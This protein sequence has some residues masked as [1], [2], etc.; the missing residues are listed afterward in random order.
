MFTSKA[1]KAGEKL[2]LLHEY[3]LI[4]KLLKIPL[5]ENLFIVLYKH[6]FIYACLS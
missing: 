1:H 3:R 6:L 5:K 2:F 4:I